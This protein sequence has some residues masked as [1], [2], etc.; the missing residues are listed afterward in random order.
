MASCPTV[1][2]SLK[3]EVLL[4]PG[5][6]SY[7]CVCVCLLP[8]LPQVEILVDSD[9]VVEAGTLGAVETRAT[10]YDTRMSEDNG[11]DPDGCVP[12]FTRVSMSRGG[13]CYRPSN[14]VLLGQVASA[15]SMHI[16]TA[17]LNI[18][19]YIIFGCDCFNGFS[20]FASVP[21]NIHLHK[22]AAPLQQSLY[23]YLKMSNRLRVFARRRMATSRGD[24][25]GRVLSR[26]A[27]PTQ[28][29]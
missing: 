12:S 29:A 10:F 4:V 21:H 5:P 26:L 2:A 9:G 1:N 25:V 23:A 8:A 28:N 24:P 18:G 14:I 17:T 7:V 3:R 15:C 13:G 11:C 22:Q 27:D 6:A 20:T 19:Q 16:D